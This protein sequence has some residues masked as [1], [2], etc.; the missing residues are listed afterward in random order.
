MF[1]NLSVVDQLKPQIGAREGFVTSLYARLEATAS[2]Q[3][4]H[5]A[6]RLQ[7]IRTLANLAVEVTNRAR[8]AEG[9][10]VAIETLLSSTN[11]ESTQATLR[12]MV[13]LSYDAQIASTMLHE[14]K[15]VSALLAFCAKPVDAMQQ[16]VRARVYARLRAGLSVRRVSRP[17]NSVSGLSTPP[18]RVACVRA[19]AHA[20][21]CAQAVLCI[22]NL[23]L[24]EAAEGILV[25]AGALPPL[26]AILSSDTQVLQE[27]VRARPRCRPARARLCWLRRPRARSR[28]RG[29]CLRRRRVPP[30]FPR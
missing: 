15:L 8:V 20:R 22:V 23:S 18:L 3:D 30:V 9:L 24:D 7:S 26:V 13:N 12:L 5:R 16:E 25:G 29:R 14:P 27:Q 2:E 11:D 19:C 4:Q 28:E 10:G 1:A 17:F 6:V 21:V